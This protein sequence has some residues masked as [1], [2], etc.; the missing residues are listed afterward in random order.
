MGLKQG[1]LRDLLYDVFEV[2]SYVS[3]MGNDSDIATLSFTVRSKEPAQDLVNFLEN[4]YSFILDAD[5]T[6]GEQDDGSYRVFVEM[7]RDRHLPEK[8]IEML[9]GVGKLSNTTDWKYRYY[10]SFESTPV[11][12]ESLASIPLDREAYEA[13]VT[14]SNMNNFKNF[15]S[16]SWVDEITLN[17]N[18][19]LKIKKKYADA[20]YFKVKD[21]GESKSII[22]SIKDKINMNEFAEILFLTKYLGDYNVTKFG[23]KTLTLENE[24]HALVV[25]RL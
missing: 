4:G 22:E 20:V 15:F 21:F 5:L 19:V 25:E 13:T 18:N 8:I 7:E 23:D 10:K 12:V 14:E 24:G 11:T 2:D 1:D 3:K 16:K 17:E 9:D 6:P